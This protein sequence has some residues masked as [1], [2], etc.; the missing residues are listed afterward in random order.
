MKQFS[1]ALLLSLCA[2]CARGESY[3][4]DG[5]QPSDPPRF[6]VGWQVRWSDGSVGRIVDR[7]QWQPSD[8]GGQWYYPVQFGGPDSLCW[9]L[10][11]PGLKWMEE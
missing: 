2:A 10:P 5:S 3:P 4:G 11:E 1:A 7:A 9:S 8:G 6:S